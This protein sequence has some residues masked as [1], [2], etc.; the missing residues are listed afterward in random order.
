MRRGLSDQTLQKIYW[1][2]GWVYDFTKLATV[3]LIMGLLVHYF[4]FS[5][6]VVKGQ[7]MD[8]NFSDGQ[9]LLI[10]KV[11]YK[12]DQPER[13]DVVALYFP[14]E[15]DNRLI[16]RIV[17]L[18]GEKIA[19]ADGQVF[20]NGQLLTENYLTASLKTNPDI[21]KQL[22][23]DEYFVLGDNRSQSSDSRAWGAVPVDYIIGKVR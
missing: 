9:V 13:G 14:G 5:V 18:P 8:P 16:K 21:E 20:I 4:F 12:V 22:V 1:Y 19:I 6:L 11:A 2:T 3:F 23:S 7:S 10:N 15:T 17:G